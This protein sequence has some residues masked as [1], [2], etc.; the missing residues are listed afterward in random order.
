MAKSSDMEIDAPEETLTEIIL[1]CLVNV[2]LFK[3][4]TKTKDKYA[5][6]LILWKILRP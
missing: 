1:N 6:F 2:E 4:K 5:S 3:K